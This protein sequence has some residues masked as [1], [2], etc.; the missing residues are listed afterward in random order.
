MSSEKN[1]RE[2]K[3]FFYTNT[4]QSKTEKTWED[5][6]QGNRKLTVQSPVKA[7]KESQEVV[8]SALFLMTFRSPVVWPLE[9]HLSPNHSLVLFPRSFDRQKMRKNCFITDVTDGDGKRK[10]KISEH[11]NRVIG[12]NSCGVRVTNRQSHQAARGKL[13]SS[14]QTKT[15]CERPADYEVSTISIF[16]LF[17]PCESLI[18]VLQEQLKLSSESRREKYNGS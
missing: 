4:F 8:S 12:C 9:E 2:E 13:L 18:L 16:S 17:I 11:D 1:R 14:C 5:F 10:E 3:T 6:D 7:S 15:L